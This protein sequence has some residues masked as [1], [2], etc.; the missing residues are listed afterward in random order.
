V[1]ARINVPVDS[2]DTE[3]PFFLDDEDPMDEEIEVKVE[4]IIR[5]TQASKRKDNSMAKAIWKKTPIKDIGKSNSTSSIFIKDTILLP[6]ID[7]LTRCIAV[8]LHDRM[9][10]VKAEKM[11][12]KYVEIL[13]EEKYPLTK[14]AT[15]TSLPSEEAI[16][17]FVNTVFK[18]A[19]LSAEAGIMSIIYLN[20]VLNKTLSVLN[21]DNWRRLILCCLMLASKVWEDQ[22]VWNVDFIELFPTIN[23]KELN[24]L[25][26]CL[27]NFLE[28]SVGI[29]AS[30]YVKV[31]FDLREHSAMS[32]E[33]RSSRPMDEKDLKKLEVRTASSEKQY[34]K[35]ALRFHKSSS[36]DVSS[37]DKEHH[38]HINPSGLGILS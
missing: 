11:M 18:V 4:P 5:P 32:V 21:P 29:K 14:G 16:N 30:E 20:R 6:N 13:S 3:E 27:L 31:Y 9:A 25:E 38:T 19:R 33:E 2:D 10:Q 15:P 17:H 35:E 8:H 26:S 37:S 24:K 23:V 36:M 28:F 7:E 1:D 22:A 34:E 12:G